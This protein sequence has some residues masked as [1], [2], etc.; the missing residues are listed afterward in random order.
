MPKVNKSLV[1]ARLR[2]DDVVRVGGA[3]LRARPTRVFLSALGIAIGIA[4]MIA[5]VGISASSQENL[6]RQLEAL[7]TNLLT[8]GP[9]KNLFGEDTHLPASAV[10]MVG[11]IEPVTSVTATGAVKAAKVYRNDRI[12]AVQS[13]GIGVL[14]TY[15]SLP[16]TVGATLKSGVF[17]NPATANYPAVVLGPAA[18]DLLGVGGAGPEQLVFLGDKWFTVVGVLNPTALAPEL[19]N[20]ALVGWPVAKNSLG[21]NGFPTTIY[22]RSAEESVETVQSLLAA[23]ANP[24]APN[25]VSVSRPSDALVAKQTA[26]NTLNA[27]LLGL[28]AVALLVGGVG[29]ANTMVISILERRGEIGLR[30]SLGATRGQIRV[31][32]LTESLLLSALGGVGGVV[33]GV[34]V[35]GGY[36]TFQGWP[37]VVPP[38]ASLGGVT[39][40]LVIGAAAGLYPAI[41][42]S[43][44]S[45]TNALATP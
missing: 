42:A 32:F 23:T 5:V 35:T 17:L 2:P 9:G 26:N 10:R 6:N 21:F 1:P 44:L 34:A 37:L 31:Q 7:G 41:R 43:L 38:W 28:G 12:P 45:P 36:A 22:A 19:D 15:P 20:A 18:A 14:A 4:A 40:T 39:A 30:R 13:G 11:R 29:V 16:S 33:L 8:V 24:P 25:E 3:G 27:L